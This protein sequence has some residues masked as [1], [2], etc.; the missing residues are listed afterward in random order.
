MAQS[1]VTSVFGMVID[2]PLANVLDFTTCADQVRLSKVC[3]RF[4]TVIR[5]FRCLTARS[6]QRAYIG[7]PLPASMPAILQAET[8]CKV[9]SR[10]ITLNPP[11]ADFLASLNH[12]T[13]LW[14]RTANVF[15]KVSVDELNYARWQMKFNSILKSLIQAKK[16]RDN[17]CDPGCIREEKILKQQM[18]NILSSEQMA[19]RFREVSQKPGCD[20]TK[21]E[22]VSAYF[23]AVHAQQMQLARSPLNEKQLTVSSEE[24]STRAY[25]EATERIATHV[26]L[27]QLEHFQLLWESHRS[28]FMAAACNFTTHPIAVEMI[29]WVRSSATEEDKAALRNEDPT[30][31]PDEIRTLVF[32]S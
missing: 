26:Y 9:I 29:E 18:C 25:F 19:C 4:Q 2:S 32:P 6:M 20:C 11:A 21:P 30:I 10:F 14:Y 28:I 1:V 27:K 17:D 8:L 16:F 23:T 13:G 7:P 22:Q 15:S 3:K 12:L 5:D 31:F 24:M